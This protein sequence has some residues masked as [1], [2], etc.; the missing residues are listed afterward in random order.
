MFVLNKQAGIF[1]KL[2]AA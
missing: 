2:L 1:E